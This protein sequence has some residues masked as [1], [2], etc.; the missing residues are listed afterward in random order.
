[1]PV[2]GDTSLIVLK[3]HLLVEEQLLKALK[4]KSVLPDAIDDAN[5]RFFSLLHMVKALYGDDDN[6]WLWNCIAKLNTIRNDYAHD[7]E[8]AQI[9]QKIESFINS[10]ESQVPGEETKPKAKLA[11]ACAIL[12]GVVSEVVRRHGI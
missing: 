12:G 6:A 1:M 7:L 9:D 2:D 10:V 3:G 8:P 11:H 4:A 5:L